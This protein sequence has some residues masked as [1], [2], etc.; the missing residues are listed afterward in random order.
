MYSSLLKCILFFSSLTRNLS[1]IYILAISNYQ[2]NR[3]S[4]AVAKNYGVYKTHVDRF[5]LDLV[6]IIKI[7]HVKG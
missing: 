1:R 3:Y 7:N 6:S 5:D 2:V 4:I